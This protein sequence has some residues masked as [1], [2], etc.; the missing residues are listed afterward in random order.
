MQRQYDAPPH[1][2]KDSNAS[3]KMKTMKKE[4]VAV[5]SLVRNTLG[6][7]R[8]AKPLGWG[9]KR[10]TNGLIIHIDL[11]KPNNK[12]VSAWLKHFSCTDEPQTDMDS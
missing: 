10:M 2:L 3:P 9:L 11:H 6:V 7:K 4:G 12:L 5:R 8:H 1:S